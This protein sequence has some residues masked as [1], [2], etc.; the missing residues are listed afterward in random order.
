MD[1]ITNAYMLSYLP[2]PSAPM[3]VRVSLERDNIKV[4]WAEPAE[5]NGII[6]NYTV[7]AADRF[8]IPECYANALWHVLLYTVNSF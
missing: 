3:N 5:H 4:T 6:R 8:V 1:S 2:A 7:S